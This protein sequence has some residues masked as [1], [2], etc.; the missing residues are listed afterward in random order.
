MGKD[1]TGVWVVALAK[2]F[3]TLCVCVYIQQPIV[4][5]L[6]TAPRPW[7]QSSCMNILTAPPPPWVPFI[8]PHDQAVN[9]AAPALSAAFVWPNNHEER[10]VDDARNDLLPLSTSFSHFLCLC[11]PPPSEEWVRGQSAAVCCFRQCHQHST[12]WY[13]FLCTPVILSFIIV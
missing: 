12:S 13:A 7:A 3:V 4:C 2:C 5:S 1:V 11:F 6:P 8:T 10:E 9:T